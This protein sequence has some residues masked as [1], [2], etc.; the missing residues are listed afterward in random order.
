MEMLTLNKLRPLPYQTREAI[1]RLRVNLSY[2]GAQF[3]S[4]MV[5]SSVPGEGKSF[6]SVNLWRSL[7]E[8]GKTVLLIDADI[9]KS[10]LRNRYQITA[11]NS[12]KTACLVSFLAG[13]ATPHDIVYETN[14]S[15]GYMI[16][17]F[18]NMS[19]PV[20]LL[21]NP[22]FVD[23]ISGLSKNFDYVIVD[24]PPV[25]SV[26]DALQIA[27]CVD[28]ALLVVRSA[29]T[30]RKMVQDSISQLAGVKC[31]LIGTVLNQVDEEKNPYY[32]KY[33]KYTKYY[34]RER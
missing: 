8:T 23:L 9:R 29:S 5:T 14:V 33:G 2:C 34:G 7:A 20:L 16:P 1:N 10:D 21:S 6:I 27:R 11:E 18:R 15:G 3:K 12:E 30:P 13:Q 24:T 25:N 26:S 32:V 28:G 19:N 4:I 17:I 31:P 22:N